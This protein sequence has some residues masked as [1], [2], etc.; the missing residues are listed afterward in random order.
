MKR[1]IVPMLTAAAMLLFGQTVYAYTMPGDADGNGKV[2]S[3]DAAVVLHCIADGNISDFGEERRRAMD[4]TYDGS[5]D[6]YDAVAILKL[7]DRPPIAENEIITDFSALKSAV[8][9]NKQTIYVKGRIECSARLDL[10]TAN[11][12]VSVI[13]LKDENG[14]DAVLD[15]AKLR[16]SL[17]SKGEKGVGIYIKG[18]EYT[19][20]NLIIQNAGDCGVRVKGTDAGNSVFR[21]CVFRYNNNSGVSVTAGGHDNSFY[22]CDSYRNG[23][24]V[25]NGGDDADGFSVKLAAAGKNY[26]YNCRAWENSDDGWD[27]FRKSGET[28]MPEIDY[29]ECLAWNNGNI[30]VFTGEYDYEQGLPLDKNLLYVQ[31]IL[32]NDPDF[33]SKYNARSIS[34]W[35]KVNMQLF[36]ITKGYT[37]LYATWGG[38][39]NGYKFGSANSGSDEY[40]YIENCIAFCHIG[41]EVKGKAKGFDQNSANGL[42]YDMKNILAFD[43]VVNINMDI[44]TPKTVSGVVWAFDKAAALDG[45]SYSEAKGSLNVSE[46]SNKAELKTKVYAYRDM[47]CDHVY[48]D[49]IPGEKIC[50]VFE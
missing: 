19:L 1:F 35:P 14:Q 31:A 37:E 33:E 43:N 8:K 11:S 20:E 27:S 46:P 34:E 9:N 4:I 32:K 36:G 30:K 7:L 28:G 42:L 50:D 10:Q 18:S 6:V 5:V 13:G 29:I 22:N 12:G 15:F 41:S 44:M 25:Q 16:D 26:F 21:N 3:R 49:M 38:N 39:P 17:T 23:D 45:K 48:N 2:E 40:R 47:I 24:I